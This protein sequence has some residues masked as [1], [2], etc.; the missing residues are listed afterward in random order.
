MNPF[1]SPPPSPFIVGAPR[2][3][4]TLL[5]LMLDAHPDLCIPPETDFIP[6]VAHLSNRNLKNNAYITIINHPEGLPKWPIFNISSELF[7]TK[8]DKTYFITKTKVIRHFYNLYSKQLNKPRWG[9]KTPGYVFSMDIIHRILPEARFIHIIRDGRDVLVS[10]KQQW[11]RP[12]D[13]IEQLA[14]YWKKHVEAGLQFHHST[15]LTI[16]YERLILDTET[17]LKLICDF[18]DLEY[19]PSLLDYHED[20]ENRIKWN[21]THL[22]PDGT[23][24]ALETRLNM[25]KHST[26]PPDPDKIGLWKDQLSIDEIKCFESVAGD[27]LQKCGYALSGL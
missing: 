22:Y 8:L 14:L 11:F 16:K 26:L 18:I 25:Q 6:K 2:S 17:I 20:A 24:V 1:K 9:D 12:S 3:G 10:L 4:T 7:K 5:R 27:T 21:T 15:Q 23:P 19:L 13:D